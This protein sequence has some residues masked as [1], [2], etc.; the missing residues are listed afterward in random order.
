MTT[1]TIPSPPAVVLSTNYVKMESSSSASEMRSSSPELSSPGSSSSS[2]GFIEM[3]DLMLPASALES[4]LFGVPQDSNAT[5]ISTASF[6]ESP[7]SVISTSSNYEKHRKLPSAASERRHSL[8]TT[9]MFSQSTINEAAVT[10]PV[11]EFLC[12]LFSMLR[13]P[14]Y[15][16]LISWEVPSYDEP[17][18]MGGGIRG[19]GKIVVHKPESLQDFVLGKYYRHSKYASFQ[20]QLNYF[21]F[22]KRLHGGKKGKLSPCSYIHES[23]TEDVGSLFGLKRRPPAKKRV[24]EQIS[25]LDCSASVSSRE[26][27]TTS[28][29]SCSNKKRR[30]TIEK[31][32]K[33]N[34]NQNKKDKIKLQKKQ[35]NRVVLDATPIKVEAEEYAPPSTQSSIAIETN[36]NKAQPRPVTSSVSPPV[37]KAAERKMILNQSTKPSPTPVPQSQ[38]SQ[39]TLIELLSTSLPPSDILFDDAVVADSI[40][41]AGIP[42]WVTDDGKYHYHNVDSSLVDL[43]MLY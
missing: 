39:P 13:D 37:Q 14:S 20:R 16:D 12:H 15:A 41:D 19:I 4:E 22:K 28:S 11:P 21:G 26:D 32:S 43:A 17:D 30:I 10:Q 33:N 24:S 18:H 23:L 1:Q 9:L 5:V 8:P 6:D 7:P 29:P 42:A 34:K 31:K 2:V 25:D 27:T 3:S 35:D 40:D 36:N 38:P